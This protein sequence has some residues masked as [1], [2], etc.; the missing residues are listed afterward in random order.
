MLEGLRE[1]LVESTASLTL[2]T[3]GADEPLDR[4]I[5]TDEMCGITG[6]SRTTLWREVKAGRCVQ[7]VRLSPGRVGFAESEV[8]VWIRGLIEARA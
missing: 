5:S 7:P 8:R 6:Y 2:P 3:R 1:S 4:F